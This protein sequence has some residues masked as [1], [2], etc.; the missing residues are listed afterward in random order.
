MVLFLLFLP[1]A[2]VFRLQTSKL[3]EV[4]E[5]CV[6]SLSLSLFISV[7]IFGFAP[8]FKQ[9]AKNELNTKCLDNGFNSTSSAH[10]AH[11]QL[12][13]CSLCDID[14]QN[15]NTVLSMCCWFIG[16]FFTCVALFAKQRLKLN[17]HLDSHV[18]LLYFVVVFG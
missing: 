15:Q 4:L 5:F 14:C 11:K 17:T 6:R 9:T 16:D 8:L 12:Y 3:V 10:R 1:V 2:L 13:V 18:F 7:F